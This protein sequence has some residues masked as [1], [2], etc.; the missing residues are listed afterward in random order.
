M[1][2][3]CVQPDGCQM[4]SVVMGMNTTVCTVV[5]LR[6]PVTSQVEHEVNC[7]LMITTSQV[8]LKTL[9]PGTAVIFLLLSRAACKEVFFPHTVWFFPPKVVWGPPPLNKLGSNQ[10]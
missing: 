10:Q 6:G 2:V 8:K 9:Y 7:S 1:S 4:A 3:D 5:A